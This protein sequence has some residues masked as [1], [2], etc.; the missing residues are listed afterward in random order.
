MGFGR[1]RCSWGLFIA[2]VSPFS[3]CPR[4]GFMSSLCWTPLRQALPFCLRC[5]WRP[6]EFPGFM[7]SVPSLLSRAPRRQKGFFQLSGQLSKGEQL[8][9][10]TGLSL[11]QSSA[12]W[13]VR[14]GRH[15]VPASEIEPVESCRFPK[16]D[17][18]KEQSRMPR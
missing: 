2:N 14:P 7:V 4:E 13:A 17:S 5:S 18:L 8:L 16:P 6:L 9:L 11:L 1:C 10:N 12:H 15:P 3:L